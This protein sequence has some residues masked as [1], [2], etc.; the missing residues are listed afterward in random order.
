[1]QGI[2]VKDRDLSNASLPE[3][4]QALSELIRE[5]RFRLST[6]SIDNFGEADLRLLGEAILSD[7]INPDLRQATIRIKDGRIDIDGDVYVNGTQI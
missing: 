3:L 4:R 1:M 2:F 5:I 6:M 7:Q